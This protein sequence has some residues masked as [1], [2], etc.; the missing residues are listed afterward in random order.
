MSFSS[1][2][3]DFSDWFF[4]KWDKL[5]QRDLMWLKWRILSQPGKIGTGKNTKYIF[6]FYW[7]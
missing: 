5:M 4:G 7:A 1:Y 6:F 2:A 3:N